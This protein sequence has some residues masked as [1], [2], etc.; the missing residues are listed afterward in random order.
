[1]SENLGEEKTVAP[2]DRVEAIRSANRTKIRELGALMIQAVNNPR[3]TD[4]DLEQ[5]IGM[6]PSS[7]PHRLD[8]AANGCNG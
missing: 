7:L 2:A 4:E 5:I 8:T 6:M 1:M 3:V